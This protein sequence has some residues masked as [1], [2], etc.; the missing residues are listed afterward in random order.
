M[1]LPRFFRVLLSPVLVCFG[2]LG[3]IMVIVGA[4]KKEASHETSD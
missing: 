1:R 4:R 3:I 2:V